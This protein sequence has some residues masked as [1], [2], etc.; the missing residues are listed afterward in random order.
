MSNNLDN[1]IEYLSDK[2]GLSKNTTI[3]VRRDI[4]RLIEYCKCIGVSDETKVTSAN[5]NSYHLSLEKE[6]LSTATIARL[7]SSVRG[8]YKYLLETHVI[9]EVPTG[10]LKAERVVINTPTVLTV[11]EIDRLI[12]AVQGKSNKSVRDRAMLE[13]L[14]ATGIKVSELVSLKITDVNLSLGYLTCRD[15]VKERLVPFGKTAA[16]ALKEYIDKVRPEMLKNRKCDDLFLSNQGKAMSRQ[17]FWKLIKKYAALAGIEKEITPHT[18]RHSF[19]SHL[20]ENGADIRSV[21]EML[22]HSDMAVTT[23]IYAGSAN[24]KIR[25]EYLKAHPR[26]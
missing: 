8:F 1:Y 24:K 10:N 6:G 2:K 23:K 4:T 9:D 17:A 12:G 14:Y 18:I 16:K 21:Q 7:I 3:S 19:A 5:L 11:E 25:E 26:Q 20:I 15:N 13:I 22:G